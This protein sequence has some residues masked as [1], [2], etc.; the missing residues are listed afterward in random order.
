MVW[1][2]VALSRAGSELSVCVSFW[3]YQ[4]DPVSVIGGELMLQV[5]VACFILNA[6]TQR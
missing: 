6:G 5:P 1:T 2:D 3:S 4:V